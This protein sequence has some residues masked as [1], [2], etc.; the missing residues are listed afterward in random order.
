MKQK[1]KRKTIFLFDEK[2]VVNVRLYIS[3]KKYFFLELNMCSK[4]A[5]QV[6]FSDKK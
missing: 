3:A 4:C 5:Y 1:A 6:G 2:Y